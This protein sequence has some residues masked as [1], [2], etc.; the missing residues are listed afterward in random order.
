MNIYF[1]LPKIG[2]LL[3][4]HEFYALGDEP[5][6]FVCKDEAD[7]RYLCSCCHIGDKWVVGQTDEAALVDL[8]D[9]LVSIR[10]VFE[11]RWESLFLVVWNGESYELTCNFPKN[12]LPKIGTFLELEDEKL[13]LFRETLKCDQEKADQ[14]IAFSKIE[15]TFQLAP[16]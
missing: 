1:N 5:I 12:L 9:D 11:E 3:L 15:D 2:D 13:G 8:I 14:T 16:L 7:R 6:L 4:E 10:D